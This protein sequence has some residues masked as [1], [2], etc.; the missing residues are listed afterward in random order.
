MMS[1]SKRTVIA[2]LFA[3]ALLFPALPAIAA[4]PQ[5][6]QVQQNPG[7][8][9]V[10]TV[11]GKKITQNDLD[12]ATN[13]L[14]PLVTYHNAV[15]EERLKGIQKKALENII[16][17]E[18]IYKYAKEN[19]LDKVEKKE[20]DQQVKDLKKKLPKG[21][22]LDKVL[23]RSNLTIDDLKN[24]FKQDIV[25]VRV[26][27]LKTEEFKKKAAESVNEAFLRD[28]YKK[29]MD[30]FKEPE[31]VHLRSILIKAD[32]SGGQRVWNESRKKAEE[33]SKL[34][35]EGTDFAK[36][37]SE[38]SEDPFAKKGGDMGWAHKGSLFPE[39]E[40]AAGKLK[41]GEISGPVMT[42][43]G[44][45]VLKIEGRKPSVQKKFEELNQKNLE[46]ELEEKEFK[47]LWNGW[48]DGIR[49][50]SKI[51]YLKKFD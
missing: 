25:V 50:A 9:V 29:N 46:H 1:F 17:S 5:S 51:E 44:Y 16:N 37:A 7:A 40:E 24:D 36:L 14:M 32:P 4:T 34:A 10:V 43:Y 2:S 33:I 23:K 21:D 6:A 3:A 49:K 19:K 31:Q 48:L 28:Y 20:I 12:T 22:S 41:A 18:L 42:I 45:H 8:Q 30:K 15:S 47:S 27:K 39:I 26:S 11:N 35:K 13:N 38:R